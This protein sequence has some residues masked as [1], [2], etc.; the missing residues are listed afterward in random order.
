MC[1]PLISCSIAFH[2][3]TPQNHVPPVASI[4]LGNLLYDLK[5]VQAWNSSTPGM[6][7]KNACA[8]ITVL[9]NAFV[10]HSVGV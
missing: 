9:I 5:L 4:G 7:V 8:L 10:P 2:E 1:S 6:D 3:K